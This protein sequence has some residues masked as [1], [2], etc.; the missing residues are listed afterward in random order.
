MALLSLTDTTVTPNVQVG[1]GE[2]GPAILLPNGHLFCIGGTGHT[3]LYTPP[4]VATQP[5]AWTAGP[6]LPPDTSGNNF[7]SPNGNIQTAI[8]APAVLLPG[9]HVL[10]VGGNTVREVNRGQT[11]FW[12]N[13][14]TAFVYDP[15]TNGLSKLA[16]QPPSN[17]GDTWTSR[18]LLLPTGQV[19]MTYEQSGT[20]S[21]LVDAA[22]IGVP[23]PTWKPVITAF[24]PVMGIGH[25]YKISGRQI[26]GLSQGC[27]YGDDAQMG[28]NYPL[29]KFTNKGSGAISY[30]R[31]FDFSTLGVA[32]QADIH[33]T[34][35]EIPA[36]AAIGDYTLQVVADGIASDPVDVK[37][38]P[39]APA[40][41]INLEDNMQFGTV[42]S[43]APRFL[44]LEVFNVGN[45]GL[46]VDSVS[47]LFGS[48]D[49]SVMPNPATPLTIAAGDHVDFTIRFVP[50]TRAVLE[51]A[52]IRIV[53][54][55]PVRPH[56]DFRT[57]GMLGT[58]SLEAVIAHGGNLGNV[59]VGNLCDKELT[60]NNNGPCPLTIRGIASSSP[61][62][63]VPA[64]LSYP[65]VL[66]AGTSIDV[67]IR[68]APTSFGAKAGMITVTS[69]DLASPKVIPVTGTAPAPRLVTMIAGAGNFGNVCLDAFADKPLTLT[70]AG[71]CTLTVTAINSSSPEFLVPSVVAFPLTIA[72][73][74]GIEVPIRFAPT[75][76]GPQSGTITVVSNDPSGP[77]TVAV[78]GNVPFGKLAICGSTYFG[79]VDC[80]IAQKS[81]SIC[82]VGDCKLHVTSVAF[83]RKRR[84]FKLIN[85]PFP[86][87]LHP[88]SCLCVVIQY[89][90]CCEP[91]CCEL[92]IKSDDPDHPVKVLDVVAYTRCEKK[93]C[94]CEEKD[95]EHRHEDDH[96]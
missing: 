5:G 50:T 2:I 51:N 33:S 47:R 48:A 36:G 14:S 10:L 24:T 1:I 12:S 34:L 89:K 86:A 9:G 37:L 91:E 96:E 38:V 41:A 35:M 64:V 57:T 85:N 95:H 61:E 75:A 11:Q 60:L 44:T 88:G 6:H 70:N 32:T 77:R 26:N 79:E 15:S 94:E 4:A 67:P 66:A 58:G 43:T 17:G 63:Q 40:I 16:S 56:F 69:D 49:F 27:C 52:I 78:S 42:C 46:I 73:G 21:I 29:A 28:T 65:L 72:P 19:L 74:T 54:D 53:S 18:F 39:K 68:F 71:T 59:C 87:T 20:M 8:D 62:F 83:S 13:P 23:N 25:H 55:D 93:E 31:T 82:N 7:N 45:T 30:F 90:A 3:A 81:I 22:V 92:V 84:H 80:G 76:R